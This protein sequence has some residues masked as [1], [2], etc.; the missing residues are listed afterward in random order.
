MKQ[1]TL[2]RLP[3]SQPNMLSLHMS[4]E[5]EGIQ[6]AND[7]T[8]SDGTTAGKTQGACQQDTQVSST[9][10]IPQ[11]QWYQ[12]GTDWNQYHGPPSQLKVPQYCSGR[13]FTPRQDLSGNSHL[14]RQNLAD[15]FSP[16]SQ[17]NA[18]HLLMLHCLCSKTVC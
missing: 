13:H 15:L 16:P 17:Y 9:A 14:Q 18:A 3:E 12:H 10:R 6:G 8:S 1:K 7:D 4:G 5:G 11:E 2:K